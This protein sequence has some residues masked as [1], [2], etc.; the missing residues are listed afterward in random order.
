V[1][2]ERFTIF[3][4]DRSG[5][6]TPF[7]LTV[8]V[9]ERESTTII[10]SI[11]D[12]DVEFEAVEGLFNTNNYRV[13]V[14]V[15]VNQPLTNSPSWTLYTGQTLEASGRE[16]VYVRLTD[17]Q[18][19][20]LLGV[21]DVNTGRVLPLLPDDNIITGE[22]WWRVLFR[23][24][25]ILV[26]IVPVIILLAGWI[27][28]FFFL[29]KR[30]KKMEEEVQ[31]VVKK[32]RKAVTIIPSIP[33]VVQLQPEP[34]PKTDK[35]DVPKRKSKVDDVEDTLDPLIQEP[36]RSAKAVV[37]AK[38]KPIVADQPLKPKRKPRKPKI[39]LYAQVVALEKEGVMDDELLGLE[40]LA[41]AKKTVKEVLPEE[42]TSEPTSTVIDEK[43]ID[44]F[45]ELGEEQPKPKRKKKDS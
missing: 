8:N 6:R 14:A 3:V 20:V 2:S 41:P 5:N 19:N 15:A 29:A 10:V 34:K 45:S 30:R 37:A 4:S 11:N 22:P 25:N 27:W 42:Q 23:S 43:Q 24:G 28:F 44:M 35:L 9:R 7:L 36:V 38:A 17:N 26:W 32:P 18:G 1:G 31:P 39:E 40:I 21:L 33:E 12:I 13:E 16:L